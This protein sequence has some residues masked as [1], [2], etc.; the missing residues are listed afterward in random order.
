MTHDFDM[1]HELTQTTLQHLAQKFTAPRSKPKFVLSDATK[2]LGRRAKALASADIWKRYHRQVRSEHQRWQEQQ[3]AKACHDWK[4]YR[5]HHRAKKS[6]AKWTHGLAKHHDEDP[7][8]SIQAHF[9]KSFFNPAMEHI[10]A[11]LLS[12]IGKIHGTSPPLSKDEVK[13]AVLQGPNGKCPGPDG[14]PVELLKKLAASDQGLTLL[15]A[16]YQ[17]VFSGL[18]PPEEWHHAFMVLLGKTDLPK[19]PKDLRP[20]TVHSQVAKTFARIVLARIRPDLR[21]CSPGQ[22]ATGGRRPSD[23]LWSFGRLNQ[24]AYEWGEPF[25]AIKVDISRAFD[26]IDRVRLASTLVR[27]LHHKPQE[28]GA[29]FSC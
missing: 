21:P 1:P 18:C 9:H 6:Q 10:D 29:C 28:L 13:A 17:E 25:A 11:E 20:I 2:A 19:H 16:F 26:A 3:C 23:F 24:L 7:L 5:H 12:M 22:M 4:T 8:D 15:H 14:V 27:V